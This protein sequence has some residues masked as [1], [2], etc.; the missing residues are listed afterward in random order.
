MSDAV[1]AVL[2]GLVE[3][4]TEYLPISSTGHLILFGEAF[5][6]TGEKAKIFE[7]VI[8]LGAIL[9]VVFLF[10]NRFTA[11]FSG[12]QYDLQKPSEALRQGLRGSAGIFKLGLTT[13][14]AVVLG[15][16]FRKEIKAH[17]FAPLPVAI[18]FAVGGLLILFVERKELAHQRDGV[19]SLTWKQSLIIGCVQCLALW[20]GM[21]RSASAIIGGMLSGLTR[22]AAAE[23]SFLAAVPILGLAALHDLVEAAHVF[24]YEDLKLVAI[25]FVVAFFSALV[26]VKWFIGLVS[27]WSLKPFAYYRLAVAVVVVAILSVL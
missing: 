1:I 16:L 25:G 17:L 13:A 3:G 22:K 8:Q 11:L 5:R 27:K 6:F 15:F 23:F 24:T 4:F 9:S 21:S 10:R 19:E 20:P 2:L 18:A 26:S 14:P 7:V 12:L